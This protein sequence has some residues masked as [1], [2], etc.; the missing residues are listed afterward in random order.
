[1]QTVFIAG[2]ILSHFQCTGMR[3]CVALFCWLVKWLP[4]CFLDT[5]MMSAEPSNSEP[6]L[7]KAAPGR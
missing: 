3:R 4:A 7:C 1:M 5:C 2:V 6:V